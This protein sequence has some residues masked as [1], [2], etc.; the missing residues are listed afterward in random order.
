MYKPCLFA[1][2]RILTP[3][4]SHLPPKQAYALLRHT[5]R[6][7]KPLHSHTSYL[8]DYPAAPAGI[9]A[10]MQYLQL[11]RPGAEAVIRSFFQLE[12]R[13]E[14][15]NIWLS[16]KSGQFIKQIIDAGGIEELAGMIRE[17]GPLLLLSGHTTYYFMLLWALHLRGHKIAF[18]MVNPRSSVHKNPIMQTSLIQSSDALAA[19]MPV[20]FTDEGGTVAKTAELLERGYTVLMLGDI[21]GYQGHGQRVRMFQNDF[22]APTGALNISRETGRPLAFVFSYAAGLDQPYQ[23][24]VSPVTDCA[25]PDC[26]EQWAAALEAV[27]RRSPESW[28]GWFILKDMI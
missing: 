27:V 14:L 9:E 15:E 23:V 7:G 13:L 21:P 25:G 26:L 12:T 8:F 28:F 4:I 20:L 11:D 22:W 6:I 5:G 24:E 19:V 17:S 3:L 18:M 1:N 2:Y 16:R 10:V